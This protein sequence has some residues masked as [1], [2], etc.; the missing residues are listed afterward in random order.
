MMSPRRHRILLITHIASAVGVLG[1]DLALLAIGVSGARGAEPDTVYPA[2]RLVAEWVVAPL[3]VP[4]VVAGVLLAVGAGYSIAGD[5][6]LLA[7]IAVTT[8]L[9]VLLL[10]V[11]I[12][13][14]REAADAALAGQDVSGAQR[15][16]LAAAPA[17]SSALLLLNVMPGVAKPR[18]RRLHRTGER[19]ALTAPAPRSADA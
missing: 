16:R 10:A 11:V 8:A 3:A 7:K 2:A 5:R 14:L 13:A 12:P 15:T 4:T 19:V 18:L 17:V 6:W 1:A 9:V